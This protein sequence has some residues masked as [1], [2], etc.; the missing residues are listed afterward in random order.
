MKLFKICMASALAALMFIGCSNGFSAEDDYDPDNPDAIVTDQVLG[1]NMGTM[2]ALAVA[3]DGD[4]SGRFAR[5]A[6]SEA[7]LLKILDDGSVESFI[8]VPSGVNLSTVHSI[9][10]SPAA[11]AKEI[12]IVFNNTTWYSY[13][14]DDGSWQSGQIGQLLCVYADGTYTDILQTEDGEWKSLNIWGSN[15]KPIVFDQLGNMY[16]QVSEGSNNGGNSTSVIYK[17]DP[18]KKNSIQLTAKIPNTNYE[19]FF[20][21]KDGNWLFVKANIWGGTNGSNTRYIR[22]IPVTDPEN[23][24]NLFYASGDNGWVND[25]VYDEDAECV[26]MNKNGSFYRIPYKDGTYDKSAT[27]ILFEGS[28]N[29]NYGWF[30]WDAIMKWDNNSSGYEYSWTGYKSYKKLGDTSY[31]DYYFRE[32]TT[33]EHEVYYETIANYLLSYGLESLKN[34]YKTVTVKDEN[35]DDLS[36]TRDLSKDFEIRFDYFANVP[37]YELLASVTKDD[38]GKS[39]TNAAALKAITENDLLCLIYD[40]FSSNN[41]SSDYRYKA[42]SV[43][44]FYDNNFYADVLYFKGTN[45]RIDPSWIDR[46]YHNSAKYNTSGTNW[47]DGIMGIIS[48]EWL[49]GQ[50]YSWKSDLLSSD[51]KSLDGEKFI[52]QLANYCSTKQID[53]SLK[54]FKDDKKYSALYTEEMNENAVAFLDNK[55]RRTVLYNYLTDSEIYDDRNGYGKF[56]QKTCFKQGTTEPAYIW[57][58][59]QNESSTIYWGNVYNLTTSYGK[60]LYGTY[61]NNLVEIIDQDGKL[62]GGYASNTGDYSVSATLSAGNG[63]FFRSAILEKGFNDQMEETGA[64]KIM[65]YDVAAGSMKDCF[66]SLPNNTTYEVVSYTVGGDYLYCCLVKGFEISNWK[67]NVKDGTVSKMS[68]G[69]KMSQIIVVK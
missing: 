2:R 68:S 11:D 13:S 15:A 23:F 28:N 44:N 18:K 5:S 55:A 30:N 38:N 50:G 43:F 4:G 33:A 49:N 22:A 7:M 6:E 54:S 14:G 36:K 8:T 19:E 41:S 42:D 12:Y 1:F 58:T 17:Y 37:G 34:E 63:F 9:A 35:N 40:L 66:H 21:S 46:S 57:K 51:G 64:H 59:N 10:Q 32:P 16:Y 31:I 39:L 52:A 25:W 67:I 27:E 29:G 3:G 62:V 48:R 69:T 53:F 47:C 26:Y 61:N 65:Y 60:S 45:T 56:L 20:V 24:K